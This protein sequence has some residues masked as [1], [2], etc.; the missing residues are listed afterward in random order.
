[1]PHS[2]QAFAAV[3]CKAAGWVAGT[4]EKIALYQRYVEQGPYVSWAGNF[5]Q[6]CQEPRFDQANRRYLIQ[7]IDTVR[8]TLRPYKAMVF[9]A[10]ALLLGAIGWRWIRRRQAKQ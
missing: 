7:P 8:S 2:S 6:Q 4:D 9:G 10:S 5:G 3:L 1:M